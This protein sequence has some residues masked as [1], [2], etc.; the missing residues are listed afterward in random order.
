MADVLVTLYIDGAQIRGKGYSTSMT[1]EITSTGFIVNNTQVWTYSGDSVFAGFSQNSGANVYSVGTT[2]HIGDF[3]ISVQSLYL[4]SMEESEPTITYYITNSTELTSVAD[5]IRTKCGTSESLV[6]PTE[7]VSAI[8]N[9]SGN[10]YSTVT[11]HETTTK[12]SSYTLYS[13]P[14]TEVDLIIS[15]IPCIVFHE[16]ENPRSIF[17][18][19]FKQAF[20]GGTYT[21]ISADTLS[22]FT[23]TSSSFS[24]K[25]TEWSYN[26]NTDC[27]EWTQ[28]SGGSND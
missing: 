5:A 18:Y 3:N 9:M 25:G 19:L 22:R 4:N 27:Y 28:A 8:E 13:I 23:I 11:L 14:K 12:T 10:N 20:I 6:Y 17:Q 2:G 24:I 21:Y 1:F 15:D 7:F 16:S 26:S